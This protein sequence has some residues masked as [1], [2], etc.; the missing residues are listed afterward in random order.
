LIELRRAADLV[1]L[2]AVA[3]RRAQKRTSLT[4]L[5]FA[6]SPIVRSAYSVIITAIASSA[7]RA[8][9][10]R[11]R[12]SQQRERCARGT[13]RNTRGTDRTRKRSSPRRTI[14][15]NISLQPFR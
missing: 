2:R 13:D 11:W 12:S 6:P 8:F 9:G 7:P 15:F 10:R 14:A 3:R 5:R 1:A 4:L